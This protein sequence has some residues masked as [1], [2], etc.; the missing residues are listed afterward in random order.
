[1][2]NAKRR[3]IMA[4]AAVALCV[5]LAATAYAF[6]Y[7]FAEVR[8]NYFHTGTVDVD[9]AFAP[10]GDG[11]I[12][13]FN[14]NVRYEP[15]MTV[16]GDF[17]VTNNSTDTE[18]IWCRLYFS[19]LGGPLADVMEAKLYEG[20]TLLCSG[21]VREWKSPRFMPEPFLLAEKAEKRLTL[22][23]HYPELAGNETQGD[24]MTFA[25]SVTATQRTANPGGQ[26]E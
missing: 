10:A 8:D 9:I 25:L 22:E 2:S 24:T 7:L 11:S 17:V 1:M 6:G 12:D 26:F 3:I 4:I 16:R 14:P 21:P 19:D 20:D 15:G 18:G 5:L 13:L 23:L